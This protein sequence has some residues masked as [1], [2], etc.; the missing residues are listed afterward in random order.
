MLTYAC[1]G[2]WPYWFVNY[3]YASIESINLLSRNS[4]EKAFVVL[5]SLRHRIMWKLVGVQ[6]GHK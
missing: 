3:I 6:I 1:N 4:A 5:L 2:P